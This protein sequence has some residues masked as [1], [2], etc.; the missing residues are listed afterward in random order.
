MDSHDPSACYG[1]WYLSYQ[2]KAASCSAKTSF[3]AIKVSKDN[4]LGNFS[5]CKKAEDASVGLIH[6][7][8]GG[9]TPAP[10]T[11]LPE[12]SSTIEM[13]C[14]ADEYCKWVDDKCIINPCWNNCPGSCCEK[15]LYGGWVCVCQG[16]CC[17]YCI[18]VSSSKSLFYQ[19]QD[20]FYQSHIVQTETNPP[21][22]LTTYVNG[23]ATDVLQTHA[24]ISVPVNAVRKIVIGIVAVTLL[25]VSVLKTTTTWID[26][27]QFNYYH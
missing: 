23:S 4:C 27:W 22:R 8:N 1:S 24:G 9:T 16:N 11:T 26:N 14:S 21:V 25:I 3:D 15:G 7:C 6:S 2:A 5:A 17:I 13:N 19:D 12:C 20:L 18:F 10:P